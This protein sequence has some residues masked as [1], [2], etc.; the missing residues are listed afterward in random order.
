MAAKKKR[1]LVPALALAPEMPSPPVPTPEEIT[2]DLRTLR[3]RRLYTV[4]QDPNGIIDAPAGAFARSQRGLGQ[5]AE[6]DVIIERGPRD[7]R[8]GH[9]F[10]AG[11]GGIRHY[12]PGFFGRAPSPITFT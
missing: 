5:D 2:I 3:G 6:P 7:V 11:Q 10:A 4:K 12:C 8:A 1:K 9:Q